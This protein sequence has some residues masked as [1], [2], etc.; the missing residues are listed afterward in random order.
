MSGTWYR[1]EGRDLILQVRVQPRAKRDELVTL[2]GEYLCIRVT[3]P[4]V[5]GKANLRLRKFLAALFQVPYSTVALLSGSTGRDKRLRIKA[6]QQL[7]MDIKPR[8]KQ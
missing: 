3:A 5:D 4:P 1:W 8:E 2:Q 6:P 7:P